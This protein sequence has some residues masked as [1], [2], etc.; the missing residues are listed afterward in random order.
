MLAA[1]DAEPGI[2]ILEIGTGTG[3][4]PALLAHHIS[5]QTITSVEIDPD[6]AEHAPRAL[7]AIGYPVTMITGDGALGYSP[8]APYDRIISTAVVQQVPS[9]RIAQTRPDGKILTPWER[10]ITTARWP[11]S[12]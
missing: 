1:L 11:R 10:R 3:Y 5:T 12:P 2:R 8:S 4:N 6:L 7:T 9:P